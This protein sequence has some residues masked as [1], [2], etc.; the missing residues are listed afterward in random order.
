MFL[1]TH[2]WL[3]IDIVLIFSWVD[4]LMFLKSL[5]EATKKKFDGK[6]NARRN[7][8]EILWKVRPFG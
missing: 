8:M 5:K 4:D 3:E 2:Q 1:L 7:L 6:L